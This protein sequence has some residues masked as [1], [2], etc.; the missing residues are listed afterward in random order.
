MNDRLSELV[1]SRSTNN[2]SSYSSQ[3]GSESEFQRE[4]HAARRAIDDINANTALIKA[5]HQKC[6][7]E[8]Q[9]AQARGKCHTLTMTHSLLVPA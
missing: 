8:L 9:S 7:V 4:S 6:L 1:D 5:L 3:A 2:A